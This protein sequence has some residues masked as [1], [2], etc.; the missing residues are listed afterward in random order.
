LASEEQKTC[1]VRCSDCDNYVEVA[2][3]QAT[4]CPYC[5]EWVAS[6]QRERDDDD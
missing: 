5:G 6:W 4:Q 3:G 1:L 2:L